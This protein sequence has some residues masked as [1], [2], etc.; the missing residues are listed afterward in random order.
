MIYRVKKNLLQN[1][2]YNLENIMHNRQKKKRW[3]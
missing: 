2:F 1:Y 3:K